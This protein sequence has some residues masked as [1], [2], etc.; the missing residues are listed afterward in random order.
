[1]AI[2]LWTHPQYKNIR[3]DDAHHLTSYLS[4]VGRWWLDQE[5]SHFWNW[6]HTGGAVCRHCAVPLVPE[7]MSMEDTGPGTDSGNFVCLECIEAAYLIANPDDE[8]GILLDP[9][10]SSAEVAVP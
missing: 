6:N 10:R 7:E 9:F 2:V 8:R 3:G 1:M 4:A 5:A